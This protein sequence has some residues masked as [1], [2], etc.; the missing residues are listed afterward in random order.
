MAST[1]KIKR[2]SVPSKDPTT[3]DIAAGELAINTKDRKI[4]S[5]NGTAVFSFTSD[6]LQVANAASI[7]ATDDTSTAA[8][9][10]PVIVA[11]LGTAQTAKGTSTKLY[12]N[13]STGTLNATIFNSL[14]D[15]KSKQ[16]IQTIKNSLEK[17]L[18]LRGVSF[19]WIDN[20]NKAIGVIAQ[21]VEQ[22]LP[23]IVTKNENGIKSVSY[24][25]I[26]GLLI[27]AIKEQQGSIINIEKKIDLLGEK[28]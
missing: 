11:A 13:P 10:F 5:S 15:I 21:E 9:F 16:N 19:E 24:D 1:I 6:Y 7:N 3:A 12:F 25:S 14:S 26:I 4:Y 27:E 2:S 8:S 20:K 28:K 18:K 22:V 17:V 23:E